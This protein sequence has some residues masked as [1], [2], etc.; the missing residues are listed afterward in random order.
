MSLPT[1]INVPLMSI[2]E[3]KKAPMKGFTLS[4]DHQSAVY[5]LNKNKEVGV[6]LDIEEY[7][8]MIK[9][10]EVAYSLIDE[11]NEET[12]QAKIMRRLHDDQGKRLSNKVV[13]G[14]DWQEGLNQIPDE[15]EQRLNVQIGLVY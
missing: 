1:K 6:V 7:N 10:I 4:K 14:E 2:S 15:W 9:F 11:S 12:Y 5:V 3:I 8:K 13:L